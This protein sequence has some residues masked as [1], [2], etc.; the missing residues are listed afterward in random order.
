MPPRSRAQQESDAVEVDPDFEHDDPKRSSA[1]QF[2]Y[3]MMR[4]VE[5]SNDKLSNE[6]RSLISKVETHEGNFDKFCDKLDTNF[7]KISDKM[8]EVRVAIAR[9]DVQ[10]KSAETD[11]SKSKSDIEKIKLWVASAGAIVALLGL[12]SPLIIRFAF[13]PNPVVV[14]QPAVAPQAPAPAPTQTVP[15]RTGQ[16]GR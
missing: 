16:R 11:I 2:L 15:D 5:R 10:I 3:G 7:S 9:Y 12:L 8:E 4:G 14:Y 13:P 1:T 6:V